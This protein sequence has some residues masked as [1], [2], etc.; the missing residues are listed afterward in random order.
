MFARTIIYIGKYVFISNNFTISGL[1]QHLHNFWR[2]VIPVY[3]YSVQGERVQEVQ[4]SLVEVVHMCIMLLVLCCN[5]IAVQ[6]HKKNILMA[7]VYGI[8]IITVSVWKGRLPARVTRESWAG[9]E[10]DIRDR[11]FTGV[12]LQQSLGLNRH[13][14]NAQNI[15]PLSPGHWSPSRRCGNKLCILHEFPNIILQICSMHSR[16]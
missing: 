15:T 1:R 12:C 6:R 4:S 2:F 5:V 13:E 3:L 7:H 10:R 11:E 14:E 9:G 16:Y 8:C